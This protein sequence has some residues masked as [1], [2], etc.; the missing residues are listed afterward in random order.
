[1][2]PRISF[3]NDFADTQQTLRHEH[4]YKE[5]PVSS[6]FEFSVSG[7]KMIPADEVF[8]KGKLLPLRENSTKPT[9]LKDELLAADDDY[10]DIFPSVGKGS[11]KE[12][13]GFKRS[14][15]ICPKKVD[16]KDTKMPDFFNDIIT[17][18]SLSVNLELR[19]E[20]F[21]PLEI[22]RN[23]LEY[24]DRKYFTLNPFFCCWGWE[25]SD[26]SQISHTHISPTMIELDLRSKCATYEVRDT[27]KVVTIQK[28]QGN[29]SW[30]IKMDP[31]IDMN[32]VP[33]KE[34]IHFQIYIC[35]DLSNIFNIKFTSNTIQK[36]ITRKNVVQM[37]ILPAKPREPIYLQFEHKTA[38]KPND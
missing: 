10:E 11:W 19:F 38:D 32:H 21:W 31:P 8:F 24:Y 17:V 5:A 13:F 23:F 7:Y 3:S 28:P 15:P 22:D 6:D 18:H 16:N 33:P 35:T 30:I 14:S 4:G 34:D 25:K 9:T 26:E 20:C 1:M 36:I 12:R 37:A 29:D 2:G 27:N